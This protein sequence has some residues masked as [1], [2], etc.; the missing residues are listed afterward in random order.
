MP[1]RICTRLYRNQHGTF[2]YRLRLP[3]DL[4]QK[5]GQREI[6]LSTGT[7]LRGQA[8]AIALALNANLPSLFCDLRNMADHDELPKNLT[9]DHF[10]KWMQELSKNV[11]WTCTDSRPRRKPSTTTCATTAFALDCG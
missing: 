5:L 11:A 8:V 3:P 7:E 4:Q 10:R 6:R 2:Y 9:T 1:I